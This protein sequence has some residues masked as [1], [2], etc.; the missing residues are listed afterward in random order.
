MVLLL[1]IRKIVME[2]ITNQYYNDMIKDMDEDQAVDYAIAKVREA[3]EHTQL[4]NERL[5]KT[6]DLMETRHL[7]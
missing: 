2:K 3:I 1:E 6:L 7:S 5:E 4:T